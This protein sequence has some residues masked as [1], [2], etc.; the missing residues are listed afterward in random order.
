MVEG[1]WAA[2]GVWQ[3]IQPPTV[4]MED[5]EIGYSWWFMVKFSSK[6]RY[7]IDVWRD[8]KRAA[9]INRDYLAHKSFLPRARWMKSVNNL[10]SR[11]VSFR[12]IHILKYIVHGS[13]GFDVIKSE[14]M[15]TSLKE[16]KI[17]VF[18]ILSMIH[19]CCAYWLG[20]TMWNA[21]RNFQ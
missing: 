9:G 19:K 3:G 12:C 2:G 1:R 11:T 4:K 20:L 16:I 8:A 21:P 10:C 7:W 15:S 6:I 5:G 13:I 17:R 14:C 18:W